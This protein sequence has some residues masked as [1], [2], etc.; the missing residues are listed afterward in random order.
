MQAQ[1]RLVSVLLY[2]LVH[3][4]VGDI[5]LRK[6]SQDHGVKNAEARMLQEFLHGMFKLCL[7]RGTVL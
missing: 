6:L 3:G 1:K 7:M 4:F 2:C 5:L